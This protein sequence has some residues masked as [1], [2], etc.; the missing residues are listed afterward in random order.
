MP[1][2]HRNTKTAKQSLLKSRLVMGGL[3]AGLVLFLAIAWSL[4]SSEELV[5]TPMAFKQ[6]F[7]FFC[8]K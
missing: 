4:G 2:R 8:W 6:L 5:N 1:R 7:Q 3:C